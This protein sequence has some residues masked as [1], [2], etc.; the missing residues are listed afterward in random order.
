MEPSP[1]SEVASRLATQEFLTF[2][3]TRSFITVFIRAYHWSLFWARWIQSITPH[4]ISLK[5]ISILLT[6]L[7]LG[8]PSGLFFYVYRTKALYAFLF[9]PMRATFHIH[10]ILLNFMILILF[11]EEYKLWRSSLCSFHQFPIISLFLGPNILLSTLLSKDPK[12]FTHQTRRQPTITVNFHQNQQTTCWVWHNA[13]L[14]ANILDCCVYHCF[15]R[16]KHKTRTHWISPRTLFSCCAIS[17]N[18]PMH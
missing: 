4:P 2:Y 5:Y 9:F 17:V 11:D 8:L 3:G 13:I 15:S 12:V 16:C 14:S 10:F 6:H 7:R 18:A 1:S